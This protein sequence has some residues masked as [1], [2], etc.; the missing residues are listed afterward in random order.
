MRH[1]NQKPRIK[2][3][4]LRKFQN[5]LVTVRGT[6]ARFGAH[7]TPHGLARTMLVT[8]IVRARDQRRLCDHVWLH[9]HQN[10]PAPFQPGDQ[11]Q[12][13]ALVRAYH[14]TER[15]NGYTLC[16]PTNIKVI[17]GGCS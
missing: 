9:Y 17:Q 13:R 16:K 11:I 5:K 12:F 15:H 10:K 4:K 3:R 1:L 14:E 8:G 7:P 6:F 2:R